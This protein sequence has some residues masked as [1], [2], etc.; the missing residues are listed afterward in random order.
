[1]KTSLY[2][3]SEQ[4]IAVL[5]K[6][7]P[8]EIIES[9]RQSYGTAIKML[10]FEGRKNELSELDGSTLYTFGDKE[11]EELMPILNEKTCKYYIVMPSSY[12]A[13]PHEMGV[14]HVSY[15]RSQDLPF[16]RVSPVGYGVLAGL[17][18]AVLGGHEPYSIQGNNMVFMNMDSLS[19]GPLLLILSVG[20]DNISVDEEINVTMDVR[21]MIVQMVVAKYQPKVGTDQTLNN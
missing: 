2:K 5:G 16:V 7:E 8:Q 13:L 20:V 9:V 3:L 4:V 10:Y 1:M 18:S 6:G 14:S 11:G 19:A 21:D 12:V 17:K 15:L